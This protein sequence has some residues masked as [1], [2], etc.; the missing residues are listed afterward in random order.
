[1]DLRSL[2]KELQQMPLLQEAVK[3]AHRSWLLPLKET[4][5]NLPEEKKYLLLHF[6]QVQ[7]QMESLSLYHALP[8]RLRMQAQWLVELKLALLQQDEKKAK[9]VVKK[10][11]H[12][13]H[14]HFSGTLQHCKEILQELLKLE[15]TQQYFE[16]EVL[17]GVSLEHQ[18]TVLHLPARQHLKELRQ[19]AQQQ[20]TLAEQLGK[21]FVA[22]A[23][24]V[25]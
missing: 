15:Q 19:I 12:D 9:F 23:K 5:K 8:E 3:K 7:R 11:A 18:L 2:K 13:P 17:Q 16:K 10:L 14:L 1:M 6:R 21:S 25:R 4:L 24:E 20:K 22:L